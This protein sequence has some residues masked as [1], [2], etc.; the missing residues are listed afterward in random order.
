MIRA[1]PLQGGRFSIISVL[2]RQEFSSRGLWKE[3]FLYLTFT[4]TS[5]WSCPPVLAVAH[6]ISMS[7]C[8]EGMTSPPSLYSSA[9]FSHRRMHLRLAPAWVSICSPEAFPLLLRRFRRLASRPL[10]RPP[11]A[12]APAPSAPEPLPPLP[13]LG[14]VGE[15]TERWRSTAPA[16]EGEDVPMESEEE[17]V[18]RKSAG[19]A[20]L[21]VP[22][23]VLV[24]LEVPDCGDSGAPPGSF[25]PC[26]CAWGEAWPRDSCAAICNVWALASAVFLRLVRL[27]WELW[28]CAPPEVL[29]D[30]GSALGC[31]SRTGAPRFWPRIAG[32]WASSPSVLLGCPPFGRPCP[33]A[34]RGRKELA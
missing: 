17:P 32:S 26:C 14:L 18:L 24:L 2:T 9:M 3:P 6:R 13:L 25:R 11:A 15:G 19:E 5:L 31:C 21:P 29:R 22:W 23:V 30:F 34:A 4:T 28:C 33:W 8:T 20:E 7:R 12:P 10:P 1:M 16:L 27:P